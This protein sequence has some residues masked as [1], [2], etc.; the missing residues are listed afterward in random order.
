MKMTSTL[1]PLGTAAIFLTGCL[2]ISIGN[3]SSKPPPSPPPA[4]ATAVV[5]ASD[6]TD[7]ATLAEID[8]AA[9]LSMDNAKC[10]ALQAIAQRPGLTPAAQ[11]HVANTT[12]KKL[13]F[14]NSK[15]TVLQALIQNPSFC[16]QAKQTI[17]AQLS[18]LAMDNDRQ[19]ILRAVNE[20]EK[21]K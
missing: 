9:G 2:G 18:K 19:A 1:V 3:R 6:P 10:D 21:M 14:D 20:R 11:V 16:A 15:V 8:A 5:V 13:S 7:T 12:F 17:M 4:P